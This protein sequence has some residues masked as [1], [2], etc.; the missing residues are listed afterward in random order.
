MHQYTGIN[1]QQSNSNRQ[2]LNDYAYHEYTRID[3]VSALAGP[4]YIALMSQHML[5]VVPD[6]I[7]VYAMFLVLGRKKGMP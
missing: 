3:S 4:T 6:T 5:S 2:D 7:T 1:K